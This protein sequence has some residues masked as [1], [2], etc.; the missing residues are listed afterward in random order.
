MNRITRLFNE[1]IQHLI[2]ELSNRFVLAGGSVVYALNEF[3]PKKSIGDIDFFILNESIGEVITYLSELFDKHNVTYSKFKQV[4]SVFN[5][6]FPDEEITL[7]FILTEFTTP[8][9]VINNFDMD[10]IRHSRIVYVKRDYVCCGFYKEQLYITPEARAAH[11]TRI[12][13]KVTFTDIRNKRFPKV[14]AKGF[15][16][17]YFSNISYVREVWY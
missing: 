9:E 15:E 6:K 10:T 7:Q 3:V 8:E 5:V 11:E 16:L 1:N 12:V 14:I 2:L 4:D 17:P 13:A